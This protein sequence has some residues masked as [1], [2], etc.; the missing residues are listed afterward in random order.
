MSA[1]ART[2]FSYNRRS[3]RVTLTG[4]TGF[5]GRLLAERLIRDGHE[6]R[7]LVR[8]AIPGLPPEA[9]IYL[10]DPPRLEAPAESLAGADAIINL[11]GTPVA[12]RWT[13]DS[14]RLMRSS[15]LDS[16]RVLIEAL[17]TI[18]ERP[19]I[20]LNASAIGFYGHRGDEVLTETSSPGTRFLANLSVEWEKQ[21]NL[22]RALGMRVNTLR[23][24]IVLGL[25]GGALPAMLGPFRA[26]IGGR[27]G[28]GNQWMSWIHVEDW[29]RSVM[30]LL[31]NEVPAGPVNLVS[32]NPSQNSEFTATLGK[33]LRRPAMIPVPAFALKML[34]GEM[35]SILL[36]SQRVEPK[37]LETASFSFLYPQL[38]PALRNLLQ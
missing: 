35:S 17:S 38:E 19:A 10:W 21:A 24:G 4:A 36:D 26:G 15:R 14:Q 8:R 29:V 30:H 25:G 11:A 3:M 31:E 2:R 18:S 33:V 27:L 13:R 34:F 37:S 28:P 9:Q 12:Q 6:V 1:P 7:L 22:G 5:L 32:P 20:L 23:T 16:T